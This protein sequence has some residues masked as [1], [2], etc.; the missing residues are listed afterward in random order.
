MRTALFLGLAGCLLLTGCGTGRGYEWGHTPAGTFDDNP[1]N[2]AAFGHPAHDGN[3]IVYTLR[4]G[5]IDPDHIYGWARKTKSYYE[6]LYKCLKSDCGRFSS[7]IFKV[8]LTYPAGWGQMPAGDKER[9]ARDAALEAAQWLAFNDGLWHE[10]ATWYGHRTFPLIS[11]FESALSWEDLY[12]DRLGT[13]V[14]AEAIAMGG[15]FTKNVTVVTKRELEKREVVDTERARRIT[16]TMENKAFREDP[17]A[18]KILWRSLDIG[19]GDG[20]INPAVFEGFSDKE[21]ITLPAP[22]LEGLKKLGIEAKIAVLGSAP[23]YGT[24]KRHAGVEGEFEP[25]VDNEKI[26]AVIKADAI[27]RGFRVFD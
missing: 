11:D 7:G 3:G 19:A 18:K 20:V 25:A 2:L 13:Y 27:K 14:A 17:L 5:S 22:T 1:F 4:A 12:S 24:I 10:M 6:D 15:N 16:Q 8:G 9:A 23:K 26:L 21:P